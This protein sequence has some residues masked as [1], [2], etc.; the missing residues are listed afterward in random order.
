MSLH[1]VRIDWETARL[2]CRTWHRTHPKPPPGHLYHCAVADDDGTLVGVAICGRPVARAEDDGS[3]VEINRTVTDGHKNANS[4]LY[5]AAARIGFALGFRRIIT[6]TEDAES[7]A[8]L[9]AAGYRLVAER[10]ARAGWNCTSRPR[11]PGRDFV[12]RR[13]WEAS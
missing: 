4:M 10:P 9:R 12:P 6:R 1:L 2:F 3:T 5:G 13:L 8:S 11:D 7:G